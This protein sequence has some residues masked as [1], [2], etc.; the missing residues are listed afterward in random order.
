[1]VARDKKEAIG[2]DITRLLAAG[3]I[4]EVYHPDWLAIPV[5]VRKK[6]NE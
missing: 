5:L 3:F 4:N 2:T 1:M 6:N